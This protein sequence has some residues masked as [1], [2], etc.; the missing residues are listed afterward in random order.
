MFKKLLQI[1]FFKYDILT[2]MVC[3]CFV[4]SYNNKVFFLNIPLFKVPRK[5]GIIPGK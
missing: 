2:Q 5:Y 1:A 3:L 4:W